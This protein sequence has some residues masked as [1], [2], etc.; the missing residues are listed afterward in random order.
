VRSTKQRLSP[1]LSREL[2]VAAIAYRIQE[3]AFG[4]LRPEPRRQLSHFAQQLKI[5]GQLRIHAR[6]DLAPGTR[7]M[8]E[9]QG[10]S[11]AVVALEDGFS[12]QGTHYRSLSAIAGEITGNPSTYKDLIK[13]G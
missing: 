3:I 13:T 2:L 7:L 10:R 9:W 5:G 4:G 8:R 12:W 11:Y 1:H 6:P